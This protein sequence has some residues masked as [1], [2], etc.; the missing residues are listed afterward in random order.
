MPE[1]IDFDKA[2]AA[3]RNPAAQLGKDQ[4]HIWGGQCREEVLSAFLKAWDFPACKMPLAI[5]E[6]ADRIEFTGTT[7]DAGGLALIER[8]RLFGH[9]GDLSLRRDGEVFLWHFIGTFMPPVEA[10]GCSFWDCNPQTVLRRRDAR[11]LL[12]GENKGAGDL[13]EEDRTGWAKLRYPHPAVDRLTLKYAE[14]SNGGQV[15]FV[16]WKELG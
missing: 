3:L 2:V 9:G 10:G 11:A 15:A 4:I 8:A 6:Y 13:W 7:P 12:W 1:Q 14:L 5:W 16:W